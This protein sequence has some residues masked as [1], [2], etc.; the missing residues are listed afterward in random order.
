MALWI[1]NQQFFGFVEL[2]VMLLVELVGIDFEILDDQ[3]EFTHI[4]SC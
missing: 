4:W 1:S 3:A 2:F